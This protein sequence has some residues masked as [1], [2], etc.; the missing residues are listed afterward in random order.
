MTVS[1]LMVLAPWIVFTVGLA[2]IGVALL[3]AHRASRPQR[4][5][6]P[7]RPFSEVPADRPQAGRANSQET[8]CR[9]NNAQA[10]PH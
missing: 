5:P 2:I 6:R 9:E 3:R 10:R 1:D 8:R 7:P 4:P